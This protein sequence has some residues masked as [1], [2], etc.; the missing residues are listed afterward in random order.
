M[1]PVGRID[2]F[3]IFLSRVAQEFG[4][5]GHSRAAGC[6]VEGSLDEVREKIVRAFEK[7]IAGTP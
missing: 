6:T 3:L 5:G 4:G 1:G 2:Y 7:L